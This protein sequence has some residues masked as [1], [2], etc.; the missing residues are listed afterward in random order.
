M[1]MSEFLEQRAKE[2]RGNPTKAEKALW[3]SLSIDTNWQCQVP[4]C[5]TY[6][7]NFLHPTYG[8]VIEADGGYH[9]EPHQ[10]AKDVARDRAMISSGFQVL[11]FTNRQILRQP[12]WVMNCIARRINV[13][14][15][16][17]GEPLQVVMKQPLYHKRK[18]RKPTTFSNHRTRASDHG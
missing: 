9:N 7:A 6:I 8:L 11:R 18:K 10:I 1:T 2:M 12:S 15:V 16:M 4:L 3:L 14:R 17:R 13:I 5:D